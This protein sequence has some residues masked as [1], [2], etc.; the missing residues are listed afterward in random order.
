V[1]NVTIDEYAAH[2]SAA[3]LPALQRVAGPCDVTVDR[4]TVTV[5]LPHPYP[6]ITGA[7][8]DLRA[9]PGD[10]MCMIPTGRMD[11]GSSLTGCSVGD[12]ATWLDLAGH[13]VRVLGHAE[14]LTSGLR[15]WLRDPPCDYCSASGKSGGGP[16][17]RCGGT[18]RRIVAEVT[19]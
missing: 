3:V 8:L 13:V 18:G 17:S 12:A 10:M 1:R 9:D 5:R 14:M 16:C 4:H 19:P 11:G 15:I 7:S 2:L 6:T